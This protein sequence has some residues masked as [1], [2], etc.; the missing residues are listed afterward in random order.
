MA[1]GSVEWQRPI[2]KDGQ[3]GALEHTVFIDFGDV[4]DKAKDLRPRFGIG[5]GLRV[6]TPVG[7]MEV[8]VAYGL[9]S[10]KFRLHFSVGFVF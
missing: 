3:P 10:R 2:L 5:T 1:I 6:K 7:P 8:D 9:K 4:A